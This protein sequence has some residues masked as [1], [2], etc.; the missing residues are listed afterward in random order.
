MLKAF[1]KLM[2]LSHK[3]A[4]VVFVLHAAGNDNYRMLRYDM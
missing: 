1:H 3:V 4:D 2:Q